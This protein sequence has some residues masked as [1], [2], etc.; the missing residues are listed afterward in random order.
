ME[1]FVQTQRSIQMNQLVDFCVHAP[2]KVMTSRVFAFPPPHHL[3]IRTTCPL[4]LPPI[5]LLWELYCLLETLEA[6]AYK[7]R[8]RCRSEKGVPPL[9]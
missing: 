8:T 2:N 1:L 4:K 3:H 9:C 6:A 7:P 5:P